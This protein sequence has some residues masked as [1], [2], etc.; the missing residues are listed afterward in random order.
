M[1][2]IL[3]VALIVFTLSLGYGCKGETSKKA[4]P[5]GQGAARAAFKV[6][7]VKVE[8][9]DLPLSIIA[10]GTLEPNEEVMVSAEVSAKLTGLF[11]DEGDEVEDGQSL[12][13]LDEEKFVLERDKA[14]AEL[15]KARA[16]LEFAKKD[17]TRK[18]GLLREGMV[19]REDYDAALSKRDSLTSAVASAKAELLLKARELADSRVS[20]PFGGSISKRYVSVGSY[21][22]E[23][24]RL[25][26][27]IDI[28]LV[29]VSATIP[30]RFLGRLRIGQEVSLTVASTGLNK[31]YSGVIYFI[32]PEVD[33]KNRSFEI[34]ARIENPKKELRPG[35]FA[36]VTIV[37]GIK[38]GVF[39]VPEGGV[40]T[41][42]EKTIVFVE[43]GGKVEIRVVDVLE[44]RGAM[45]VITRG[46]KNGE[47][48]VIEGAYDLDEGASV[49]VVE[50]ERKAR[51]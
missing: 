38:K 40:L 46:L 32:S 31:I 25:F 13:V 18:S 41:R 50:S 20:A 16:E 19:S 17:L 12:V 1:K 2:K 48:V 11:V 33:P 10:V 26:R 42:S 27:L 45:A 4:A 28:D 15:D 22:R 14:G 9:V 34:K 44:R 5:S 21:V 47:A 30:E 3:L 39:L 51:K 23:G 36:E 43:A 49:R 8:S 7:T 37:T 24:D 29:K 35:L 6:R